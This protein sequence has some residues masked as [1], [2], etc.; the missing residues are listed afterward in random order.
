MD[1]PIRRRDRWRR[2]AAPRDHVWVLSTDGTSVA[3]Q[4]RVGAA[5]APVD[6]FRRMFVYDPQKPKET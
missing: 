4:T 1:E 6:R 2:I 3:Y 5:S